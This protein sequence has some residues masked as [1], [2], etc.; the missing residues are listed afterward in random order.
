MKLS[1]ITPTL[2]R[3]SLIACMLSVKAQTFEDWEHIVEVD[4]PRRGDYGN[5]ARHKAWKRATGD[6][7]IYLDDD[8]SLAHPNALQDISTA[9]EGVDEKWAIFPIVR[10]GRRFFYDPPRMCYVDTL[11]MVMRREIARWPDIPNREADGIFCDILRAQYPYRAFPA[12]QPIG[13]MEVSSNGI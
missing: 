11:N 6:W 4:H 2:Q 3:P 10:H 12:F 1:I 9:L 13:I 8:N 7:V 5:H